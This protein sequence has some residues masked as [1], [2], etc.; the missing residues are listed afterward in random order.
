MTIPKS[1]P[2]VLSYCFIL[3]IFFVVFILSACDCY[4]PG[5]L[6]NGECFKNES[7]THKAGQCQCKENVHG[8][9]CDECAN[10]HYGLQVYNGSCLSKFLNSDWITMEHSELI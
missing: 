8:R 7:S 6:N 10:E 1:Y 2:I 3:V 4:L 5:T 9:K